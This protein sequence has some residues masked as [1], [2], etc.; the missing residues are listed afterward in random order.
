VTVWTADDLGGEPSAYGLDGSPTQVERIFSPE[1]ARSREVWEG[2]GRELG[3]R[4]HAKL[5]E[6]K[7][8]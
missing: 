4:L 6:L 8:L 7:Q 5:K 2:S 1:R 3:G